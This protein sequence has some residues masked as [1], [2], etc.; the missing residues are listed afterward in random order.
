[1]LVAVLLI[2]A[3]GWTAVGAGL[4]FVAFRIYV[5]AKDINA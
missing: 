4:A 3:I 5:L 2:Q 1:M